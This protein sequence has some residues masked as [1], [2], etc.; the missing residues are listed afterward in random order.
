[1]KKFR[2]CRFFFY[3]LSEIWVIRTE[4]GLCGIVD[5]ST[6]S[7]TAVGTNLGGHTCGIARCAP[8]RLQP[9]AARAYEYD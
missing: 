1:M 5:K 4:T 2:A 6:G 9:T 8:S 3:N 7:L